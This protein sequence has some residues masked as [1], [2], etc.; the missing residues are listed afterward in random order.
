MAKAQR[1]KPKAKPSPAKVEL[2]PGAWQKFE[3]LIKS[4]AKMGHK[5]H[6]VKIARAKPQTKGR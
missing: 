5:P 1:P 3:A 2:Q 4:A 6:G